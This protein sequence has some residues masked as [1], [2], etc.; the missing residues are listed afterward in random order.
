[1]SVRSNREGEQGE[2]SVE[3]FIARLRQEIDTKNSRQLCIQGRFL[4]YGT[5]FLFLVS[6][7][8]VPLVCGFHIFSTYLE[9]L[10]RFAAK[11]LDNPQLL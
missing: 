11:C 4:I 10:N 3:D 1:M 6:C 7:A 5:V 9:I 2:M 8:E